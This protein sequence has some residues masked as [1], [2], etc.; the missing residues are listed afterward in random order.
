MDMGTS[1]SEIVESIDELD[2][3]LKR[4]EPAKNWYMPKSGNKYSIED[5]I[6][7]LFEAIEVRTASRVSGFSKEIGRD[8]LRKSAMKRPV[9]VSSSHASGIGISEPVSLKQALRGLSI[10][11]AS[12]MAAMKKR[13]SKP[14]GSSG[15][16]EAGTIKRLYRAVVVE[17]NGSRVP[18]NEG[19][20]KLVEISLVPE[21]ITSNSSEKMPESLQVSNKEV[22]NLN[23]SIL[24]NATTE[25]VRTTRLPSPDQIVPL[26]MEP[27][28]EVSEAELKKVNSI[29][30]PAVNHAAKEALEIGSSS[31][32]I[33]V[34]T[35][36]PNKEPKGNLLAESSQSV[37]GAAG[38]VKSVC[39]NPRLIK[40]VLRN[41]SFIRKKTKQES[42]TVVSNSNSC[43]GCL[44]NDL[45]P[46]TSYSDSQLQKP[47]SG[48]GTK[49][50]MEVS[51]VSSSTSCSNEVNSSMVGTSGKS[52]LS[53]N[54]SNKSK[55]LLTKAD[56][57]SRS[58][59]KGEFS[60]SSKSSIGEYSSSTAT[61]EESNISGSSRIGSR[62]HMSK[63]LRWEAIRSIRKQHGSLSLRHFKLLKKIGGGD[64]GT[65]Y[66]AELTGTNGLFALKVMNNDFLLSRKKML[67]AQTEKEI[68]QMLDHPFLPTLYAYFA[69][70]KLSCL[71]MEYCPGGD[72]HILRQKQP[73]RSF[74]EQA[75]RFYGAEVLLALEYLHMLGVV[76][77]D[78]KPENIL[79]RE[80]G[81]IMLTDFDLSLRC[82]ANPV[83]LK[84]ASPVAEPAEKMSSPCSQSSC[85]EP[86]CL[87]PSFQVP[88]FTPRLLSLASRS[89]KIKSDLATQ[90]S[91][92]P[93]LVVEPTSARS[94]S[95][96]GTHEY[97]APE[98]IKGEGH[99][100]AVDWWTFGIFLF[101]LLYGK[102]PF[103]GSGNDETLSNVVSHSLRFPS[104]PIV[105]FHARDL[106]RGLLVKEP[107][108]RLGS[109][110][111]A[112]EIKQ[113]PFFEGL[114]WALIRCA[115]PPEM[116][117]FC[118]SSICLPTAAF[119]KK[120]S[121]RGDE[122]LGT[123]DH[124]EFDMF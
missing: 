17:E 84:S 92:M 81:H 104:S 54:S 44:G 35:P 100:N 19:K 88:C 52:I 9:R 106:I 109:V 38:K 117:R 13:L 68:M 34:E 101:E 43:N 124:V 75:V 121:S 105:S 102:T 82:D 22:F 51:R 26:V 77:R 45:G 6:N 73:G 122:L 114:N 36:M 96:V 59:E 120:D 8:A 46:S 18:L 1:T 14:S 27:E 69:T 67:R 95:F 56:D 66:L 11:Q 89:R 40:P 12:E 7:R 115:I 55:G 31:I 62:P 116:P 103:K 3:E 37:S 23:S 53:S 24:D 118:D 48:S 2:A 76:Y 29:D 49:E 32:Q 50:N 64:I 25:R 33:C 39:Q 72:L 90:I 57:K 74:S 98:I 16:S 47:A 123:G 30:S 99:G 87:N 79:V 80:D 61:S 107:E 112:T 110:K 20:G 97:L 119:Q 93:Q 91:P 71:V 58:R 113:H 42:T 5:D 111:G 41:K 86:L 83:L 63:D 21:K 94:N 4:G 78:L 85:I 15:V 10:S 108:N 28:S 70:E 65:V 60:Q